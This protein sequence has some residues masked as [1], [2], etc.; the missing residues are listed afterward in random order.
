MNNINRQLLRRLK[1]KHTKLA[2]RFQ[3][4]IEEGY[5]Q[6]KTN[7][8]RYTVVERLKRLEKQIQ[9]F[10]NR[11]GEKLKMSYKHWALALAMGVVVSAASAQEKKETKFKDRFKHRIENKKSGITG[12]SNRT[13]AQTIFFTQVQQL[14]LPYP[15][16]IHV[17]DMDKDGDLDAVYI[18]YINNPII[19]SNE[20]G[21]SFSQT[22]L[23]TENLY[24][25]SSSAV[26]DFDGDGDLDILLQYGPYGASTQLAV[27]LNGGSGNF[28][29][30]AVTSYQYLNHDLILADLDGDGDADIV[31]ENEST[32][33]QVLINNNLD[34]VA[35][36][37]APL[38]GNYA[39]QH[40][41]LVV[42]DF[43]GDMDSDIV[44]RAPDGSFND[45]IRLFTNNGTGTFTDAGSHIIFPNNS[46]EAK[47]AD[48]DNDGDMD[49]VI[50]TSIYPDSEITAFLNDGNGVFT[51]QTPISILNGQYPN[52]VH[53][54]DI[55]NDNFD[56]IVLSN[57]N[58]S[59]YVMQGDGLGG[60]TLRDE[61]PGQSIP[62]DFDADADTD[63]IVFGTNISIFENQGSFTFV[64]SANDLALVSTS[65]DIDVADVDEDGNLD[66]VQAGRSRV[67]L[68]DGSGQNFTVSQEIDG[69][70]NQQ[71][72]KDLD[73]D[74]DLDL[75][76][77]IDDGTN[78]PGLEIWLN[79]SGVFT[80]NSSIGQ[81]IFDVRGFKLE[82]LDKDGD[83]D[84][85]SLVR[86]GSFTYF[87]KTFINQGGLSFAE[88]SNVDISPDDLSQF[89]LGD[90]DG[91]SDID[92]I[93]ANGTSGLRVVFNGGSGDMTLGSFIVPSG[94][95]FNISDVSLAN[96]DGDSDLDVFASNGYET[97]GTVYSYVFL[98]DGT[99]LFTDSG[100]NVDTG[101]SYSNSL[102]DLDGDGDLD[103]M[104]TRYFSNTS[105][106]IND[107]S[108]NFS[109]DH[110][111]I[112]I[113]DDYSK[114]VFGDFDNDGN[115]DFVMGGAYG[116]TIIFLNDG[117][118]T[119]SLE[120]DSLALVNL[121][122]VTNGD[123]WT[124]K[125][126]WKTGDV[127][128]WFG[129]TV[130]TDR[131]TGLDLNNNNL[132]GVIPASFNGLNELLT[133]DLS[134]NKISEIQADLSGLTKLTSIDLSD[135]NLD[136]ADFE[137]IG[138]I[139]GLVVG[140]QTP[141]D[142]PQNE[143]IPVG[144]PITLSFV[145][146]GTGNTYQWFKNDNILTD[147]TR[148][149]IVIESISREN[150]GI[151]YCEAKNSAVP[152]L[153][154]TSALKSAFGTASVTGRLLINDTDPAT[155]GEMT[156]LKVTASDGYDTTAVVDINN[157]GEFSFGSVVL[158]DYLIV[159]F[160]DTV[161]HQGALPTYYQTTGR[162]AFW[163]EADTLFLANNFDLDLVS[164]I[165]TNPVGDVGVFSG[166][167][168]EERDDTGGR[169]EARER[170][171]RVGVSMRRGRRTSRTS[172]T[173]DLAYYVYTND[174][175][176]FLI[177][178]VKPGEYNVDIQYPGYPMDEESFLDI[179]IGEGVKDKEVSIAAL[180]EDGKI[181]VRQ[182]IILSTDKE[183]SGLLMYPNPTSELIK[184][185]DKEGRNG[186]SVELYDMGG[187]NLQKLFFDKE[188][189]INVKTLPIGQY[190]IKVY[191][192]SGYE[193]L[194]QRVLIE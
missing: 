43:D 172:G 192:G 158:A 125:T 160:A 169:V 80:Y 68:N 162:T 70:S 22:E 159:G 38:M 134:G 96:L 87:L 81:G 90:I 28:T 69:D 21:L 18:S 5:F 108:A 1:D 51:P 20:G 4:G 94:T 40:R 133:V 117:M 112:S 190:I 44:F 193:I 174:N 6:E 177:S 57:E 59:T 24:I 85:F 49:F 73:G 184:I 128:T 11:T 119:N 41:A 97:G 56:D 31:I 116:P 183:T 109:F 153:V 173:G 63:F 86:T 27:W 124:D 167:L 147:S 19:F 76:R 191:D 179:T 79:T 75:V 23:T 74:G 100:Q 143:E 17:G 102:A 52:L 16:N 154:L 67:W 72:L 107:G 46:G 3:K 123:A 47:E 14:G 156:L 12:S 150:Q 130:A 176:E 82:D 54:P 110:D 180:V 45:G 137:L 135:N 83:F 171:R 101:T 168:E 181:T 144:S 39:G 64:K 58:D 175:G 25:I 7:R 88:L 182:L 78:Y 148:N 92:A 145:V 98:N 65:Y 36:P 35:A 163:A 189:D 126:N 161:Q 152:S 142:T 15:Q 77:A 60:F 66:I 155:K 105:V 55:N 166:Y 9:S 95:N 42:A 132:E 157:I 26:A 122:D 111:L 118:G 53:T 136:F 34:F 8:K 194:T 140:A 91:D 114:P 186:L 99:G 71:E 121:Y 170:V 103:L 84:I 61:F 149:Q 89:E 127:S 141:V 48:F 131:V 113:S 29:K 62:G 138:S 164:V 93:I 104:T 188:T 106:W 37:G 33:I 165:Y 139:P 2:A 10:S 32:E 30:Q 151:Y 50:A 13:E 115:N 187:N 178:G 120:A 185:I 129:V 146:D